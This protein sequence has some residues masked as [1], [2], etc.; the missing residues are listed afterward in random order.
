LPR[1]R[2]VYV[3]ER[4]FSDVV[5]RILFKFFAR[6]ELVVRHLNLF[7]QVGDFRVFCFS[8]QL[9]SLHVSRPWDFN[10]IEHNQYDRKSEATVH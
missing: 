3:A 10:P 5:K 1:F 9:F 2:Q 8:A 6:A 7:L 4:L